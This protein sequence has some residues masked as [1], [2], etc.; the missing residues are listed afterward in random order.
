MNLREL[1]Q[2]ADLA[3]RE[4]R[5]SE[6]RKALKKIGRRRVPRSLAVTAASLARRVNLAVMG[7]QI[8]HPLVR[9]ASRS[10]VPAT[11]AER[12]EY[13]ALLT[14]LGAS[15]EALELL[16]KTSASD[17]P[18][19]L[20]FRAFALFAQW[21]YRDA[22]EPLTRYLDAP[23]LAPYQRLVGKVNLAAALVIERRFDESRDL[24]DSLRDETKRQQHR[25]LYANVLELSA[26]NAVYMSRWPDA[27]AWLDE[28]GKLLADSPGLSELFVRKWQVILR[29]LRDGMS[30]SSAS[31]LDV[32][33]K[34][35]LERRHWETARECD[36]FQAIATRDE[37]L[38][39]HVHFG[40]PFPHYRGR[41]RALYPSAP[42]YSGDY[43]WRLGDAPGTARRPELDIVE[44]AFGA[45][46]LK[47]GQ[48]MHKVLL[49]LSSDF[50]Q[51][52]RLAT[53]FGWLFRG[54]YFDPGSSP[55][56]VF[57]LI[58]RT[59]AWLRANRVPLTIEDMQGGYRFQARGALTLRVGE[60]PA[61]GASA[62]DPV[63]LRL[64]RRFPTEPFS[65]TDAAG[66]LGKS[67][68]SAIRLLQGPI[69][70]GELVREGA[71]ALTRYRFRR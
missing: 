5:A 20:L 34:D 66:A 4:G 55:A 53:L 16:E 32:I 17:A 57:R 9:P 41:I 11:S 18:Q 28:A 6:A 52:F 46:R 26:Q 37:A 58:T 68:R 23:E 48:A 51:P 27:E 67:P 47:P 38:A 44:G 49:A 54:E 71:A 50:Y 8:L 45:A 3:I 7:T 21:N 10:A 31:E 13:A 29:M 2:G 42:A 69:A 65:A 15:D 14:Y 25:L 70:R 64:K 24:L 60:A 43:S 30:K 1:L 59:R 56:R 63:V 39:A 61:V 22:I 40:T 35:A 62:P 19:V 36:L 12:A 33:R